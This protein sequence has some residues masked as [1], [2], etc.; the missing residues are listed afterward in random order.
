[1][2]DNKS[3]TPPTAYAGKEPYIFVSYAHKDS[4][5]AFPF[6]AALQKSGYNVWFDDG[7][8]FGQEWEDE[9]AEK[10]LG[11]SLFLFLVSARS[12]ESPNCKDELSLA[13]D[14]EKKFVN[15]LIEDIPVLPPWFK[16][17]YKRYQDCRLF[18]F[19]SCDEAVEALSQKVSEMAETRSSA[20]ADGEKKPTGTAKADNG[21]SLRASNGD[22]KRPSAK[23]KLIKADFTKGSFVKFGSYPQR[24]NGETAPIEWLVLKNDGQKAL[25]ISK[26]A[27][28]CQPYNTSRTGVTWKTSSL[29]NWLNSTFF[30]QAFGSNEQNMIR[31]TQV[32]ADANPMFTTSLGNDT[33]DNVFLLSIPE[34]KKYFISDTA[35]MCAPTDYA[36]AKGAYA[37]DD[38]KTGGRAACWWWLRSPGDSSNYAAIV[39]HVGSVNCRGY[40]VRSSSGAVRPA[41]WINLES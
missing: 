40:N 22:V 33:K 30:N 8:R 11:C 18:N 3:K 39:S 38:Y 26:Y 15:V 25:L 31:S 5:K 24:S 28:D 10:L 2:A 34:A 36:I 27:L 37:D 6:I 35:R 12:L 16:L 19:N 41:L 17:R 23:P 9:I 7:I 13:R 29:R 20:G 14:E 4:D 1:M 21:P 32:T